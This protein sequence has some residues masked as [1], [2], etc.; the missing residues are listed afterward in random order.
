MAVKAR[1]WIRSVENIAA[2]QTVTADGRS[3]VNL[4]HK[5]TL[6][7]VTRKTEDNIAWSKYTPSGLIELFV[8]QDQAHNWFSERI[9]RDVSITFDD[10]E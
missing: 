7:P 6:S 2:S 5:V 9:G 8:T 1:F 4:N 10:P 3:Q